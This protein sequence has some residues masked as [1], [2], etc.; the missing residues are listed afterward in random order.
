MKTILFTNARDENKMLEWAVHHRNLGFDNIYIY[1][2]KSALPIKNVVKHLDYV[3]VHNISEE[4]ICK[5]DLMKQ[6]V[7][8]AKDNSFDWML[9]LDADEFLA[10]PLF[11]NVKAFI[12]NYPN[13]D[14]IC[15]NWVI[16]G[17]NFLDEEPKG[18]MLES[19]TRSDGC[20]SLVTK[21]FA[22][23]HK[24]IDVVNPHYFVIEDMSLSSDV[25]NG[26]LHP[27][28]NDGRIKVCLIDQAITLDKM[29]AYIAHYIY[30]SYDIFIKRKVSRKRDDTGQHYDEYGN[31]FTKERLHKLYN[32]REFTNIRDLYN[33]RN[34]KSLFIDFDPKVYK[35]LHNDIKDMTDEEAKKH[36]FNHGI[37]ENR[38]Y[39][40]N[41]N[42]NSNVNSNVNTNLNVN[43]NDFDPCVYKNMYD[44]L[45]NMT[46][47]EAKK[48]Y[49]NHGSREKRKYKPDINDFDPSLYKNMY[50][51]LKHM[52]CEEAENHY[53]NH[54]IHEK[55]KYKPDTNDF[56]PSVY[57]NKYDDLKDM[58]DEEAKNHYFNHGIHEGR[59]YII[60]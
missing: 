45:K 42:A 18:T 47:E 31:D 60:N 33:E 32:D 16:F 28:G 39:K 37:R 53:F 29:P 4:V 34:K 59:S 1:D 26:G 6:S 15:V 55:R 3:F 13:N 21:C 35:N 24:V 52:T 25:F 49:I 8:Y 9:Y 23:P 27:I 14:Q 11:P 41:E 17:S 36:Y 22:K 48:H 19:Y 30:Q 5:G 2:H 12:N 44:D 56:N 51:D 50:D 54:G 7:K 40:L 20:Y 57:K 38:K 43:A 46:D 58:T 10:L